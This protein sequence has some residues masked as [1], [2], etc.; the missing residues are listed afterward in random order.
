MKIT[1]TG[2]NGAREISFLA[3]ATLEACADNPAMQGDDTARMSQCKLSAF[4]QKC[5]MDAKQTYDAMNPT[6]QRTP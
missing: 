1:K 3:C 4:E 6:R 5:I 2:E